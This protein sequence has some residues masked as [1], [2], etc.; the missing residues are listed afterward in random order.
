MEGAELVINHDKGKSSGPEDDE[1]IV[2]PVE[3]EI[4]LSK[5]GSYLSSGAA[6]TAP[7]KDSGTVKAES[8]E[9]KTETNNPDTSN[10]VK[11]PQSK[12]TNYP[13]PTKEI[14]EMTPPAPPETELNDKEP[15]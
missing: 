1:E 9:K 7:E 13:L 6:P 8:G 15:E 3:G 14:G 2:I 12:M 4:D 5:A 10:T 11:G